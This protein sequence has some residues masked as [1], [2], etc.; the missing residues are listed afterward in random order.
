[1][2][3][4]RQRKAFTIVE[5]V[6]VIAVIA[7]L[8]TVLIPTIS[9]VIKKANISADTQFATS[10]TIQLAA[11]EADPAN[12]KIEDPEDLWEVIKEFY[13]EDFVLE[14]K[15]GK[16]G[17]HFYYDP[18]GKQVVLSEYEELYDKLSE[19]KQMAE[20]YAVLLS[21]GNNKPQ[22][23]AANPRSLMVK[24]ND[25]DVPRN[26]FLMD[27]GG[28]EVVDLIN[29][30]DFFDKGADQYA[31]IM[32]KLA[33]LVAD[34]DDQLLSA[35]LQSKI[36]QTAIINN[37]GAFRSNEL[38][39]V[40]YVY[41]S[42]EAGTLSNTET[43][44]YNGTA[45]SEG[46]TD[47]IASDEVMEIK[48]PFGVVIDFGGL[49]AIFSSNDNENYEGQT[50]LLINVND[51]DDLKA[52][53]TDLVVDVVVKL[54]NNVRYLVYEGEI[55]QLPLE[56]NEQ[57]GE[58]ESDP[59]VDGDGWASTAVENMEFILGCPDASTE[60]T[61]PVTSKIY[62]NGKELYIAYDWFGNNDKGNKLELE[63]ENFNASKLVWNVTGNSDEDAEITVTPT[64]KGATIT[65]NKLIDM[66]DANTF[67][68][69]ATLPGA[70]NCQGQITIYLVRPQNISFKLNGVQYS[71]NEYLMGKAIE[72]TYKEPADRTFEI[73]DVDV[74]CSSSVKLDHVAPEDVKF[75]HI[76]NNLF[77]VADG[78]LTL[79]AQDSYE[80]EQSLKV[81]LGT[82][83][84]EVKITIKNE[85]NSP[86]VKN[87]VQGKDIGELFLF[88]VGNANPFKLSDL[89][90]V[91]ETDKKLD[92][93]VSVD[94]YNKHASGTQEALIGTTV[95][96]TEFTNTNL[97]VTI[98]END[99]WG[100][101]AIDF[102]GTGIAKIVVFDQYGNS[103]TMLVEVVDG[104]NIYAPEYTIKDNNVVLMNDVEF[105][106]NSDNDYA[107]RIFI[108][109]DCT[110]FGNG[111]TIT[112]PKDHL[113][114]NNGFTGYIE[115]GRGATGGNLDNVKIVG[116]AYPEANIQARDAETGVVK[117]D[118]KECQYL[119]SSV[120]IVGGNCTISNSYISG[121][122]TAL[123]VKAGNDIL[124]D[125]TTLS[126]GAVANMEIASGINVT[127]RD[128]T[129]IQTVTRDDY[130]QNKDLMGL[131]LYVTSGST[132][133][134]L[135]NQLHQY[136]WATNK[137][138]RTYAPSIVTSAFDSFFKNDNAT[139]TY[140]GTP[141]INCTFLFQNCYAKANLIDSTGSGYH[142]VEYSASSVTAT[143]Y[144]NYSNG[145]VTEETHK[146]PAYESDGFNPI[147]PTFGFD[148]T[149]N[150]DADAPNELDAYCTYENFALN[151]GLKEDSKVINLSGVSV[152]KNGAQLKVTKY[153]NG[154]EIT[155]DTVEI[156]YSEGK[157]QV[158][159]FKVKD[160]AGY[161]KDGNALSG[162]VEYTWTVTVNVATVAFDAPVWNMGGVYQFEGSSNIVYTYYTKDSGGVGYVESVPML[163]GI[164]VTYYK[165]DGTKTDLDFSSI[166][167]H[168]T[169]SADNALVY[170]YTLEDGST[171][172]MTINNSSWKNPPASFLTTTYNGK[173]YVYPAEVDNANFAREKPT[174]RDFN[175]MITYNFTDSF[176][177]STGD[178]VVTWH[179]AKESNGNVSVVQWKTFDK[180][181]GKE[182][183][184]VTGDTLVTLADGTQKR[185]DELTYSDKI[186]AWNLFTGKYMETS[187]SYIVYHGDDDYRVMT[188]NFS[189]GTKVKIIGEHGFFDAD[190][191]R[192]VFLREDNLEQYIGHSFVKQDGNGHTTVALES[193]D[194]AVEH[195]G[196]YSL[197]SIACNNVMANGMFSLT[198]VEGI[199]SEHFFNFLEVA[200]NMKY[201]EELLQRDVEKY[202]LY[203]YEELSSYM[204]AEEFSAFEA[205]N[206]C[207][208]KIAVEKG[209]ITFAELLAMLAPKD[210]V[211]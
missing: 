119:L 194:V 59:V 162:N 73:T 58:I 174:N 181:N 95:T 15:S 2:K 110:L 20:D 36:A 27:Q 146:A 112:L 83:T 211:N 24:K 207:Y 67:T 117:D 205:S 39:E 52:M 124:I 91:T 143:L 126:G 99:N 179:N 74:Q 175:V 132:K 3:N 90:N 166:T 158:L 140:D 30:F 40:I 135:E 197:A 25:T 69:T 160:N 96:G 129:T 130:G 115:L 71:Y 11:W 38:D 108:Y 121:S 195:T 157:K 203:T 133:I 85:A 16:H 86:F 72:L 208:L 150:N 60:V 177:Q 93:A 188:L 79:N 55:Y 156:K 111:Y 21:E 147:A 64:K 37:V 33:D 148:N 34:S 180:S 171:L 63:V 81:T 134:Y 172:K 23:G 168:P 118:K 113:Q 120:C 28:S 103:T 4:M 128:L 98:T 53:F 116:Y 18:V 182:E 142:V 114:E 167:T 204:T 12:D 185:V 193:Y 187:A 136:N 152:I 46:F 43:F 137:Q 6:I 14:P 76:G 68:V 94:I 173:V 7:I 153:L 155:G 29:A 89:F 200:D 125:D 82:L 198:P 35:A 178:Q 70:T 145:T 78:K 62:M 138:T 106:D 92:G 176:G 5:M 50:E 151:I 13:G 19:P 144:T 17:Y 201:D 57:T 107:S 159:T 127:L 206:G 9:G 75:E 192:F 165:A 141:V 31:T 161:D 209:Y 139:Y 191:N 80:G 109:N 42:P 196:A 105:K 104:K 189:D 65:L 170:I 22:F 48:V 54:P 149:E 87:Q 190:L 123:Y 49:P 102:A 77:T 131:G 8:A 199:D 66:D 1:M 44:I 101:I 10:L 45:V 154:K 56:R 51:V 210:M 186:L 61:D 164:K 183:A 169:V 41:V 97:N 47:P 32:E 100:N 84:F 163:N 88:R 122:R 26:A 202:G 184:C